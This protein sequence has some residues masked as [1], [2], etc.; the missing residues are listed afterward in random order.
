MKIRVVLAMAAVLSAPVAAQAAE[1]LLAWDDCRGGNG[2]ELRQFACDTDGGRHT[3]VASVVAPPGIGQWCAF[4]IVTLF[5][6]S[7]TTRPPWWELRNNTSNPM[8]CRNGSLSVNVESAGLTGCDDVYGGNGAGGI[9]AYNSNWKGSPRSGLLT[10]FAIPM[11][12][13]AALN[14]NQEYFVQK[15]VIT[16]AKTSGSAGCRGCTE[17]VCIS[18]ESIKVVQ[19]LN[20]P[21]GDVEVTPQGRGAAFWQSPGTC[22][23]SRSKRTTWSNVKSIYR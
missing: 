3:L 12:N 18:I 4:E 14:A 22:A 15:I 8:A 19:P 21:G 23:A 9:G 5:D 6:F 20:A 11:G 13:E 10:V 16:N 1:A 7:S 2:G 17:A